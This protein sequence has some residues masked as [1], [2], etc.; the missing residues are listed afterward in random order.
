MIEIHR[1]NPMPD[2]TDCLE[3]LRRTGQ[4]RLDAEELP[5]ERNKGD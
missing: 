3:T 4:A 5:I 1:E 2:L